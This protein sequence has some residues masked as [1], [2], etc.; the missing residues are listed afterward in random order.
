MLRILALVSCL[1]GQMSHAAEVTILIDRSSS[2]RYLQSA[3]IKAF[4]TARV[5][6]AS[7]LSYEVVTWNDY[8]QQTLSWDPS[9]SLTE[10]GMT[11]PAHGT[12]LGE[13]LG[14][15]LHQESDTA[16]TQ[17]CRWGIVVI[18]RYTDDETE[19]KTQL[20]NLTVYDTLFVLVTGN[21]SS[22]LD[23]IVS[24]FAS[25]PTYATYHVGVYSTESLSAAFEHYSR[26]TC[27]FL[28]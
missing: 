22:K 6:A 15:W 2:T 4:D 18:D 7:H 8:A 11:A 28:M 27:H 5:H 25:H 23:E 20:A 19:F 26:A 17:P 13:A 1:F 24:Q 21:D 14:Y 12:K 9:R 10:I 3:I 16:R